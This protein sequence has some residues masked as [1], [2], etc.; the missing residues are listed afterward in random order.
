M[1]HTLVPQPPP[2]PS[3]S[4]AC[5]QCGGSIAVTPLGPQCA[6][7]LFASIAAD[8]IE[9]PS[10]SR[11]FGEYEL[12]DVLGR[13]GMGIVYR[14]WQ[15][16]LQRSVAL[17][18]LLAGPFASPDFA[19]RFRREAQAAARLRHHG[20]VTVFDLGDCD[21]QPYYTMELI[22]GSTLADSL[23]TGLP[24]PPTAA[25]LLEKTSRAVAHAHQ[26]GVLHRDLKPSNILL[27]AEG[28]PRVA[29]FGLAR[30][31]DAPDDPQLTLSTSLLGSPAYMAPELATG[32]PA[33]IA[34]DIYALGAVLYELLTGRP[35]HLG[36]SPQEILSH[37]RDSPIVDPR[38][39]NPSLPRD[40][41]TVCLK[42]L[43]RD[44]GRR[45]SSADSLADDLDRFARREPVL[46]RPVSP[47]GKAWRWCRRSPALASALTLS[48]AALVAVAIT[49]V[50][51]S[52]NQKR[53]A[54][55]ARS[56]E[57]QATTRLHASLIDQARAALLSTDGNR[58][59][60][61]LSLLSQ[62]KA[63]AP[64]PDI[65][66]LALAAL[67]VPGLRLDHSHHA[68]PDALPHPAP[69]GNAWSVLSHFPDHSS[70]QIFFPDK[71]PASS[72]LNLPPAR[73][74]SRAP[75][76]PLLSMLAFE[77]RDGSLRVF[78]RSDQAC[79]LTA[80]QTRWGA[81]A[82]DESAILGF[83]DGKLLRFLLPS[84]LPDPKWSS[85]RVDSLLYTP[86]AEVT[87]SPD[88]K[89]LAAAG[90]QRSAQLLDAITGQRLWRTRMP[91][92][93]HSFAWHPQRPVLAVICQDEIVFCDASS[94]LRTGGWST[95]AT[96]DVL[97]A[98]F[99]P[100]GHL[101]LTAGWDGMVRLHDW[102]HAS[103]LAAT[104]GIG[105]TATW[106]PN[107]HGVLITDTNSLYQWTALPGT[108]L[109]TLGRKSRARAVE[110]TLQSFA[111]DRSNRWLAIINGPSIEWWS[112]DGRR[113]MASIPSGPVSSL[114][115]HPNEDLL[116]VSSPSG[117]AGYPWR[118]S[119]NSLII[120]PPLTLWSG[121]D[122]KLFSFNPDGSRVATWSASRSQP[123][124][125]RLRF[126]RTGNPWQLTGGTDL[127][128]TG[129]GPRWSPDSRFV[130]D[131]C[132]HGPAV[133]V[134]NTDDG[135]E[136]FGSPAT[137]SWSG[138]HWTPDGLL[139]SATTYGESTFAPGSWLASHPSPSPSPLGLI[140]AAAFSPLGLKATAPGDLGDLSLESWP[141]RQPLVTWRPA[142]DTVIHSLAFSN[143]ARRLAM[144][145]ADGHIR[146]WNLAASAAALHDDGFSWTGPPLSI[147]N[148]PEIPSAASVS[149]HPP[150]PIVPSPPRDP[151]TPPECL[152]LSPVANL[153]LST[154]WSSDPLDP[155]ALTWGF[156]QLSP[157]LQHWHNIPFDVRSAIR[158]AGGGLL[159]RTPSLPLSTTIPVTNLKAARLHFALGSITDT[160]AATVIGHLIVHHASGWRSAIPLT[161]GECVNG[162]LLT[163]AEEPI[164]T[165]PSR[166]AWQSPAPS[167][168]DHRTI[169]YQSSWVNPWPAE[170][171][172]AITFSS[173]METGG[174]IL[175]AITAEP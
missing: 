18:L 141:A 24:S 43:D 1:H 137:S 75:L 135:S 83:K 40:L 114:A 88:G 118:E 132:W 44:P 36:S 47:F 14:A 32:Q 66:R 157:G 151:A 30:F 95:R 6:Q 125:V 100:D 111:F 106:S 116:V 39:L 45:Y 104:P 15:P 128:N 105:S 76:S 113:R 142:P 117:F 64:S 11:S 126:L 65:E 163:T 89:S 133:K 3:S 49:L 9:P 63:L 77:G 129:R 123:G 38:R 2:A 10:G 28:E 119:N 79:I 61:S 73:E 112:A 81:F 80:P 16:A 67:A 33:T 70:V 103:L 37:V 13:G 82:P 172:T 166:I 168:P 147:P 145:T 7:C 94:G 5:P 54:D 48:A 71:S 58:R 122:A 107:G 121:G 93:I 86:L 146:L 170:P 42:C 169:I 108:G 41:E 109:S 110:A 164:L 174:P 167:L 57:K 90:P 148:L 19:R 153:Q 136:I 124:S 156:G 62:A 92:P 149:T 127:Y 50:I 96:G 144:S 120:D 139:W 130:A 87:F 175:F 51:T 60:Q 131:H 171:I 35:P 8:T 69:L 138:A 101:L 159:L 72:P 27:T 78:R 162:S 21:G 26:Q 160:D 173:T 165:A 85:P 23:R 53:S 12:L 17:K 52:R 55:A 74:F 97:T 34:S 84:G 98:A 154:A 161:S 31:P 115:F 25:R 99:S 150:L 59:F 134:W 56:A 158:L 140:H 20:I 102:E 22:E 155:N 46:A 152:D 4:P 29:D 68:G 143:D 91:G